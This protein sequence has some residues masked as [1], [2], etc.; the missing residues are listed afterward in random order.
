MKRKIGFLGA[1]NMGSA[2]MKGVAFSELRWDIEIYAFDPDESKVDALSGFDVIKCNDA[3]E[4]VKE[5][6]IVFL[7]VKPQS[8]ENTLKSVKDYVK[9]RMVFV[10]IAAGISSD[11]IRNSL[12]DYSVRVILA[13]PNTPLLLGEGATAIAESNSASEKQ[14]DFV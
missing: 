1:G 3:A 13:M 5:C 6:D 2:I 12:E 9:E 10:S 7:A 4:V 14:F 8:L 11:Y